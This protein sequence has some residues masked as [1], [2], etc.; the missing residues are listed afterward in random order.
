MERGGRRRWGLL[1]QT[2]GAGEAGKL[3]TT[4]PLA[5]HTSDLTGPLSHTPSQR[6]HTQKK[7]EEKDRQE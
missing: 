5:S 4:P 3:G 6:Q 2:A 7:G 1:L